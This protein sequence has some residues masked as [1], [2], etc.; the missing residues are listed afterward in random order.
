MRSNGGLIGAKK[1]VSP[2]SASGIWAIR[3]AQREKGAGNWSA[4]TTR[5]GLILELDAG[6]S[7]SYPGS[8]ST[9]YDISGNGLNATFV[10]GTP[11]FSSSNGGKLQFAADTTYAQV[12]TS[13]LFAV[14]TGDYS[15]DMWV[16]LP[17]SSAVYNHYFGMPDQASN[18]I[19]KSADDANNTIYFYDGSNSLLYGTTNFNVPPGTW[20]HIGITRTSGVFKGYTNGVERGSVSSS[21]TLSSNSVR[22]R[23]FINLEYEV[24]HITSCRF[25]NVGLTAAEMMHNYSVHA[26][27]HGL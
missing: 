17:N 15:V 4:P 14:G 25:Y 11:S 24:T 16:L 27:R 9:W 18:R 3:D 13:S 21:H 7:S 10:N 8:G 22:V 2:T 12:T 19:W 5:R 23:P 1:T 20:R 26:T 6:N